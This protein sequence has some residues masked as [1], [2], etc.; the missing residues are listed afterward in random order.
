[1]GGERR[2]ER[3]GERREWEEE[4]GVRERGTEEESRGETMHG[5]SEKSIIYRLRMCVRMHK[6]SYSSY[7]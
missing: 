4:R 6:H 5:L 2:S 3:E 7:E 1:M